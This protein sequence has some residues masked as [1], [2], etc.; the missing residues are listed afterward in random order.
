MK[1]QCDV[2][3]SGEISNCHRLKADIAPTLALLFGVPIPKNNVGILMSETLD[4]LTD[5]Q[6]LRTLELNSWQLLRLLQAQLPGLSCGSFSSDVIRDDQ[7]PA[8]T[9]C[10]GSDEGMFC[11]LFLNAAA[12]HKSWKSKMVSR[13]NSRDDYTNTVSAYDDFLRAAREW[14]SHRA[15]YKPAGL[16]ASG[17][18]AMVL[19]CL[20]FIGLLLWLD[21]EVYLCQM[22]HLSDLKNNMHKWHLEETYVLA[23]IFILVLSMGSSSM[24][25]EEQ[26][27]WHF[28]TSTFYLVLLRKAIQSPIAG[29]AQSLI[30]LVKGQNRR[31]SSQIFFIILI[32]LSGRIMR[33]W[34]QGGVNWAHLPDISKWLEQAGRD[35][36]KYIQ[37][38]SWLLV[39]SLGLYSLSLFRTKKYFVMVIAFL[40]LVPAMLVLRHILKYQDSA[41]AASSHG[42][43]SMAQIIY[44]VLGILTCGAVF[45]LPWL[46]PV[47][48][49]KIFST[50]DVCWSNNFLADVRR[51]FL[52]VGFRDCA[53]VIGWAYML[54]WCLLQ[55]LL[56]Q[57]IN[58]MPIL[59]LLVQ[60]LASICYCSNSGLH[61]KQWVEVAALFYLGMAGH[62]ALG[63]TNTLASIDVAGAFIGISSH[64]TLLSGILMFIIT[65][66]SPLLAFLSMV[67]YMSMK[68]TSY[69]V[70]PQDADIG[71]FL[72]MTVGFP[73]LVP[74][75]LNSVLLFAY[76]IVLLLMRNHLFVWSVFSPKYLYV[77]ATTVCV[78]IGVSVVYSTAIYTSLV[79]ALRSRTLQ[80]SIR[81]ES[82]VSMVRQ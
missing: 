14:L 2:D 32:L 40:F 56:Q 34:H 75:G 6:R 13:S 69:L 76:T 43:T 47:Q 20:V 36:V 66:A 18:A 44:A 16:L 27:I 38:V 81:D 53:Y 41:F 61:L 65:Y 55:L 62:F 70:N 51:K 28:L 12:L 73:C 21:Q 68:E 67:M 35:Y 58:S 5:D 31:R 30:T 79:F 48:N 37:L 71:H 11:C 25:E 29:V 78:Y 49:P 23:I 57:P 59:L 45:A 1:V 15:T 60:I 3:L 8:I 52:L 24:V 7:W 39:I 63:N 74:L 19:S 77:C 10:D 33:G 64:S 9:K 80:C 72:K 22:H 50:H 42:A 26:Y 17:V 82:R 46:I 4:F 54:C